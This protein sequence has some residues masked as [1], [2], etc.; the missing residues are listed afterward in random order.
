MVDILFF[1]CPL[2]VL[3]Q[4]LAT[5]IEGGAV[6]DTPAIPF[7][8]GFKRPSSRI[9]TVKETADAPVTVQIPQRLFHVGDRVQYKVVAPFAY[10][11]RNSGKEVHK[12]LVHA[13]SVSAGG[14]RPY[15]RHILRRHATLEMAAA[16]F[17][18]ARHIGETD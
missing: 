12:S 5:V 4:V 16:D 1:R 7:F 14:F 17:I 3:V 15:Q 8:Q 10:A 6:C 11:E 13:A 18:T 9:V 2:K